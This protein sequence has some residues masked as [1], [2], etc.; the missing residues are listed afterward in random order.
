MGNCYQCKWLEYVEDCNSD[1]YVNENN[2][3]YICNGRKDEDVM[4]KK[5]FP[6]KSNKKCCEID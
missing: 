3:G 4:Y 6:F 5:T 1:G 2:S